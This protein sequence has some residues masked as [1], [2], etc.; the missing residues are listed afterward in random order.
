MYGLSTPALAGC[1]EGKLWDG[2]VSQKTLG[3]CWST[4]FKV[5]GVLFLVKVS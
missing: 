5:L 1:Q 2:V 4:Y 3:Y